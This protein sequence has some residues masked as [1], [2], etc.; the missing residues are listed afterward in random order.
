MSFRR[1]PLWTAATMIAVLA[2][3]F[4]VEAAFGQGSGAYV[5]APTAAAPGAFPALPKPNT[6][7]MSQTQI[8]EVQR[9]EYL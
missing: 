6:S 1:A 4:G 9:G 7:G 8:A 3:V 5:P 2:G